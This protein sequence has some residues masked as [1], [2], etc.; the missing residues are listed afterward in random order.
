MQALHFK[1]AVSTWASED[2]TDRAA[3]LEHML[4]LMEEMDFNRRGNHDEVMRALQVS[5]LALFENKRGYKFYQCRSCLS[6]YP[7]VYFVLARLSLRH[8]WAICMSPQYH[9]SRT[10]SH[11]TGSS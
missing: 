5:L 6:V 3:D 11:T 10:C 2:E 1:V 4:G 8:H 7:G 9:G